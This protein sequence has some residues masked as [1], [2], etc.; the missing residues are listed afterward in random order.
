MKSLLV[1]S[2]IFSSGL[3]SAKTLPSLE[4]KTVIEAPKE[5]WSTFFGGCSWYCGAPEIS[6]ASS[7]HLTESSTL[8]H[9]P[10]QA[11]DSKMESVW[12]EGVPGNGEGETLTFTF[13]TTKDDTTDLGVTSC[14]IATGHQ[15]STKLFQQNNRAKTLQ[16]IIDGLPT[17]LLKLND[18][19][20]L[21]RFEI[22]KVSLQRPSKHTIGFKI[23]DVYP[24]SKFQDTCISEVYFQGTGQMH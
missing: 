10:K 8:A 24:G 17:A 14:A 16:L 19:M 2:L 9:L 18:V 5:G 1:V 21:Q 11:H 12:C 13:N 3:A 23:V 6:V 22:P 4:S 15:G 20:G 7:S